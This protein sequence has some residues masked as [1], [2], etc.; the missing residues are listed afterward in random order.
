MKTKIE[1]RIV[2]KGDCVM[3]KYDVESE[4]T[5]VE[6]KDKETLLIQD[7]DDEEIF[8][9]PTNR[10]WLMRNQKTIDEKA[11]LKSKRNKNLSVQLSNGIAFV[12]DE[13][14]FKCDVENYGI[15]KDIKKVDG[16]TNLILE[17]KS[18]FSGAY[19]RGETI[20]EMEA[21]RCSVMI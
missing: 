6:V 7:N 2:Q 4:A 21:E 9:I 15:L 17:N 10:C 5:I 16:V 20:T 13:I 3:Y 8:E 14:F 1:D 11:K 19:I 18:G 12:G